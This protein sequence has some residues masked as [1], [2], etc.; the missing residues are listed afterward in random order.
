MKISAPTRVMAMNV[1]SKPFKWI[2]NTKVMNK[3]CDKFEITP[4]KAMAVTTIA[5]IVGKDSIGCYMYVKQS[6]NNEKIPEEKRSFVA[7][8]DLTNG[9]LM[10]LSQLLMFFTIS[11]KKFQNKLFGKMFNKVFSENAKKSYTK[12]VRMKEGMV[13]KS[14]DEIHQEFY[15]LK[16]ATADT[17]S[18]LTSLI[19][20]TTIAKRIIVPFIATP[21]ASW[22]QAK[23]LN[24]GKTEKVSKETNK[25]AQ[26]DLF[27]YE[28]QKETEEK[29]E[30]KEINTTN[31]LAQYLK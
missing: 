5:S 27:K 23:I 7:A 2:A 16:E 12:I 18:F 14:K 1:I 28:N 19:A 29:L 17:F 10:I 15:K 26:E 8:L 11:N 25:Q 20:S 9:G 21:M 31:L 24:K 13:A 3:I 4:E 6:L 22:A 30:N